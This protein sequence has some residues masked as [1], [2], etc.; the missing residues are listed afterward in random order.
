MKINH[1]DIKYQIKFLEK[2]HFRVQIFLSVPKSCHHF[3]SFLP[4]KDTFMDDYD[5][6]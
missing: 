1:P 2:N 6:I 3:L 4:C 5:G